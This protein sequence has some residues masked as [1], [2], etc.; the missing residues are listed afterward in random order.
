MMR[1]RFERQPITQGSYDYDVNEGK[2]NNRWHTTGKCRSM[3]ESIKRVIQRGLGAAGYMLVR[4]PANRPPSALNATTVPRVGI[5]RFS[6]AHFSD[7]SASETSAPP[8]ERFDEIDEL[9]HLVKPWSGHVPEGYVTDFLGILTEGRFLWN[10]TGPFVGHYV[11]TKFP[12]LETSGEGLFE[13]AEWFYSAREA[14]DQYVAISLGAAYGAQLVGAWK[15]LQ[16][17][18]PLP[19]RL[20]AIEPV[21][22]NCEWI[23][24]HMTTNGI[25]PNDHCIMQVA[26]GADYEPVLFPVGAPGTGLTTGIATNSAEFRASYTE[27]LKRRGHSE[28]VLENIFLYNSTGI[29]HELGHNYAGDIKFISSVTLHDVLWPFDRIDLLEVDIQGMEIPVIAPCMDLVN[30]KVRRLHVGTHGHE[31][32]ASL[33]AMFLAARWEFVFDYTPGTR[34]ITSR[35]PLEIGDGILGLRNPAV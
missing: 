2:I 4:I 6:V 30:R 1:E 33:R 23:R 17:I 27:L 11:S 26:L 10:K 34:H 25:D 32:H 13:I 29:T 12:T 9:L 22:Q 3:L 7:R 16:A 35:G 28:R 31:I 21:P 15:T 5:N 18:N 24:R 20:V 8:P 19:A 14:V